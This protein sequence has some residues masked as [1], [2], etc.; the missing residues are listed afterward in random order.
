MPTAAPFEYENMNTKI[1]THTYTYKCM[2]II[3]SPVKRGRIFDSITVG[4]IKE[5]EWSFFRPTG[6]VQFCQIL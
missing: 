4:V 1:Y 6:C 5:D 2:N 3:T